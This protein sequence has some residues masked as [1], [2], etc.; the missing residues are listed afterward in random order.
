MTGNIMTGASGFIGK[1]LSDRLANSLTSI[2]HKFI[3]ESSF[4]DYKQVFFLSAYGNMHNQTNMKKIVKANVLDLEHVLS[5]MDWS[6]KP[7]LIYIS[8]SS[9]KLK[10]QTAYSRTKKIGEEL[11]LAYMEN[12]DANIIIVRPMSVTGVGEQKEHLIPKLIDSC[13]NGTEMPFVTNPTH[14]FIDVEDFVDGV[15]TL[16]EKKTHGIFEIGRGWAFSNW[17]VKDVVEKV[18]GKKANLKMV[19]SM[20]TYDNK[21]WVSINDK[22][23]KFGWR[24]KKTL[25]Q[26]IKEM[27]D[28]S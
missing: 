5:E 23:K 22:I 26:S 12:F 20:R 13:L 2:G 10:H 6:K 18:T 27:V 21:N 7:V 19:D 3:Q 14:D 16:V 28:E 1:H 8:T 17:D 15:M 4:R 9:V 25:T 24:A 11:C